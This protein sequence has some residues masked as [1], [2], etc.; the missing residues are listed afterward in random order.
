MGLKTITIYTI[1]LALQNPAQ[2]YI[3]AEFLLEDLKQLPGEKK[4]PAIFFLNF[5]TR[6]RCFL[7]FY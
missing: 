1:S 4:T 6:T 5:K 3:I 2:I 7:L